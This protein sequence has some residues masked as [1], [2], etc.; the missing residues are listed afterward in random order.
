MKA[1][2]LKIGN[3]YRT[4]KGLIVR[5]DGFDSFGYL[6][7]VQLSASGGSPITDLR[8]TPTD[9][10]APVRGVVV[11]TPPGGPITVPPTVSRPN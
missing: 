2:K 3:E 5:F 7:C 10:T 1:K 8:L 4:T 6:V 9:L 11:P